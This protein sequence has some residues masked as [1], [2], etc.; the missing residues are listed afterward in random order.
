M[1]KLKPCKLKFCEPGLFV[2]D[3]ELCFKTEYGNRCY[4][5][6]T[7]ERFWGGTNNIVEFNDLIVYPVEYEKAVMMLGIKG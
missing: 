4:C 2:F 6:S 7:G 1:D 5:V 3:G